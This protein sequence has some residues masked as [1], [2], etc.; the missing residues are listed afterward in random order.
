[1]TTRQRSIGIIVIA[2]ILGAM[3]GT[4]LGEILGMTLPDGVVRELF[5]RS[6]SFSLGPTTLDLLVMNITLGFSLKLNFSGIIGLGVAYY[7]LRYF[8]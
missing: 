4:L 7:L 8:R 5:L 1:M 2:V 3:I 6:V